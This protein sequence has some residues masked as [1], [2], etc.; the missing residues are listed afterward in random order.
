MVFYSHLYIFLS[1]QNLCSLKCDRIQGQSIFGCVVDRS[2]TVCTRSIGWLNF[3]INFLGYSTVRDGAGVGQQ[4]QLTFPPVFLCRLGVKWRAWWR[5]CRN[6][7]A[8]DEEGATREGHNSGSK[9]SKVACSKGEG[10]EQAQR[11][12]GAVRGRTNGGPKTCRSTSVITQS[13]KTIF[14]ID[15]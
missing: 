9:V 2:M 11:V 12:V 7:W 6:G 10:G 15:N 1:T 4:G 5:G 3:M 8:C 13:R 14:V